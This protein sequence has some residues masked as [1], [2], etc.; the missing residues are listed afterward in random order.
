MDGVRTG[1]GLVMRD[2]EEE[3]GCRRIQLRRGRSEALVASTKRNQSS[4]GVGVGVT[5]RRNRMKD[6]EELMAIS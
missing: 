3:Q 1:G 4:Y 6:R 2:M 5:A